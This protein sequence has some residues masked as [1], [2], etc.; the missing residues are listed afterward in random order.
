MESYDTSI[1]IS[2]Y[3]TDSPFFQANSPPPEYISSQEDLDLFPSSSK[4]QSKSSKWS[5][6]TSSKQSPRV[7]S[8]RI[9]K[10][11]AAQ[12]SS[13]VSTPK[14]RPRHDDSQ[15]QFVPVESSPRLD[16]P[17]SQLLTENQRDVRERQQTEIAHIFSEL[18][19][20]SSSKEPTSSAGLVKHSPPTPHARALPGDVGNEF[21]LS[22][23][24]PGCRDRTSQMMDFD[25]QPFSSTLEWISSS[26][27]DPPSSPV[28]H[29]RP[30]QKGRA[31]SLPYPQDDTETPTRPHSSHDMA[32]KLAD[33]KPIDFSSCHASLHE[34]KNSSNSKADE[35]QV[36]VEETTYPTS[37]QAAE[38]KQITAGDQG[39][40][41]EIV[42]DSFEQQIASQL[43]QDLELSLDSRVSDSQ[44]NTKANPSRRGRKRKRGTGQL[45]RNVRNRQASI[46]STTPSAV[47]PV[48]KNTPDVNN[49]EEDTDTSKAP[50][51][52]SQKRRL[53]S[54]RK[55]KSSK[56]P[57]RTGQDEESQA[58]STREK[59]RSLRLR[60]QPASSESENSQGSTQAQEESSPLPEDIPNVDA[61]VAM[62]D[63]NPQDG[64][65]ADDNALAS[66]T[67][68]LP[69]DPILH[70][71]L[72]PEPEAQTS[73]QERP[74]TSVLNSLKSILGSI[75]Q[76][77][78]GRSVLREIDDVM[79]DL[80]MEAHDAVRRHDE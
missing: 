16:E 4:F 71:G 41:T 55:K 74:G 59:R 25:I 2:E 50:A 34:H 1:I 70:D 28:P 30:N 9:L 56:E 77:S 6:A 11:K 67:A 24:T 61:D 42:P 40:S 66:Q 18:H 52:S 45:S 64:V 36:Y 51:S 15:M 63:A 8:G 26:D 7:V 3:S 5:P 48:N 62:D 49:Q 23:P 73:S 14:F 33:R 68:T 46:S 32:Q 47:V 22:S 75:K 10:K 21:A 37:Q 72:K 27:A 65:E 78:F 69:E 54:R 43:E 39:T 60:G 17:E 44:G 19:A 35:V 31:R 79:F 57:P 12:K 76:V 29:S 20:P 13:G 53:A 80:R 58:S 38:N